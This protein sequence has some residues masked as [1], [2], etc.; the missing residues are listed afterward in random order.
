MEYKLES[1]RCHNSQ[2]VIAADGH[3]TTRRKY[4]ETATYLKCAFFRDD[5]K[6]KAKLNSGTDLITWQRS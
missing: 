1:Y 3:K 2:I 5:S 4:T 6:L